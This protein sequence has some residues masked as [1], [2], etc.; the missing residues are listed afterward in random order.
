MPMTKSL[1]L[2]LCLLSVGCAS[3][4]DRVVARASN[5]LAYDASYNATE[6]G[7]PKTLAFLEQ[8]AAWFEVELAY[9]PADSEALGGSTGKAYLSKEAKRVF[10]SQVLGTN[11]RLEVLAHE[12]AHVLA[13]RFESMSHHEVFAEAVALQVCERLG[14]D[15]SDAVSGYLRS[16][17][18][19]LHIVRTHKLEI[20]F[21]VDLLTR[22]YKESR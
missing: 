17:K 4:I 12:L 7:D 5:A 19:N 3:R 18:A 2:C 8:R 16:H 20:A 22:G 21:A 13:P 6:G 1:A 9:V 10:I 11:G 15:T 14:V